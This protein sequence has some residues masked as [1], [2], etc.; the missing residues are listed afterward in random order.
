[1]KMKAEGVCI[2]HYS[3]APGGIEVLMPEIIKEM[4]V[5]QVKVFV[6]R[7]SVKG[8]L[9]VYTNCKVPITIGS[10]NNFYATLRL[11]VF[12][13]K[14]RNYIFHGFNIG[15]FFLLVIR[16]A[17]VR[18]IIYSIR[19]TLYYNSVL[20]RIFRQ[21]IWRIAISKNCRIIANSEYSRD[22]F[23]SYLC[24]SESR[25]EIIYNP[26]A[27]SRM[28]M[29][30]LSDESGSGFLNIGY[31]GRL[32]EGKNLNCWIDIANSVHRVISHT[33]F[34]IT[35]E[36]PLKNKLAEQIKRLG[37]EDFIIINGFQKDI[38]RV[39]H[40]L[41]LLI[42]LSEYESFGNVV[43]ESILCGKPVVASSIPSIREIFR[44]FPDFLVQLDDNLEKSVLLKINDLKNLK[45]QVPAAAAE[46][47]IR[48]SFQQH[49]EKLEA[50]Y[51]S[52]HYSI[53]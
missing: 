50:V 20:Q 10:S 45:S 31:V 17:A 36:G 53:L 25:I 18:R 13:L 47:K 12:A 1:M 3:S 38:A 26:V 29:S 4:P 37:A 16:L 6:I 11:W 28:K 7:P 34:Y 33:K 9:N 49:L 2:V 44:N 15:P 22:I 23:R 5:N 52:F 27:S 46:F 41:D 8:H 43:V 32:A 40:K 30:D 19:G 21:S 51:N 39:Y 24:L 48:F 42:F 35:G 14:N